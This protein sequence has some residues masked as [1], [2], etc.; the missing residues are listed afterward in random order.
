MTEGFPWIFLSFKANAGAL[1]DDAKSEH[2]PH[3]PSGVE[4]SPKRLNSC[5]L[6]FATEPVWVQTPDSQPTKVHNY[7]APIK[8][9]AFQ[10]L[11][12]S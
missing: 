7:S 2:G 12:F 9:S 5:K 6:Q 3:P 4:A 1:K 8:C 11:V 10:T